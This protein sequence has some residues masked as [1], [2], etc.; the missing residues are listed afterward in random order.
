MKKQQGGTSEKVKLGSAKEKTSP[1][2]KPVPKP[3]G[4]LDTFVMDGILTP[5]IRA[6]LL[7]KRCQ[8]QLS[9]ED[10][11]QKLGVNWS[12]LRKWELGVTGSC[13]LRYR[14]RLESFLKGEFDLSLVAYAQG[15]IES[16]RFKTRTLL[17]T[18]IFQLTEQLENTYKLCARRPD[19]REQLVRRMEDVALETLKR[20]IKAQRD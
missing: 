10:L 4:V 1:E 6:M 13:S 11:S 5:E 3:S 9:Y 20:L 7:S 2:T 18:Q 15:E 19:V 8:L 16:K 12:T 17:P 14:R